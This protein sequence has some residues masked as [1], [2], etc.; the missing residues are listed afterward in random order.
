MNEAVRFHPKVPNDLAEAI[1][2]YEDISA[3][4]VNRFR[5]AVRSSFAEIGAHPEAYGIVFDDVR[6]VRVSRFP[7]LVQYRILSETAYVLGVFH[8]A[9]NPEKWHKRAGKDAR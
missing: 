6:I 2:W 8:S 3:D 9:S 7:Y 1:A 5:R 4:V